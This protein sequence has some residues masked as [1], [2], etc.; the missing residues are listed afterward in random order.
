MTR[1]PP[2]LN[3]PDGS[4]ANTNLRPH[5]RSAQGLLVAHGRAPA[6]TI[7]PDGTLDGRF[8][9]GTARAVKRFQRPTSIAVDG[10]V[11]SGTEEAVKSFQH[12]ANIAVDGIVGPQTYS[13]LL[14][15]A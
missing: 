9:P 2:T 4:K 6:N 7:R 8:G 5:V 14:L 13:H 3:Q 15:V 11:G 12:Q 1:S 10:I